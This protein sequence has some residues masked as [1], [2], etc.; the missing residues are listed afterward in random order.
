MAVSRTADPWSRGRAYR[1]VLSAGHQYSGPASGKRWSP[2]PGSHDDGELC[3]LFLGG[4]GTPAFARSLDG[5]F[6]RWHLQNGYHIHQAIEQAF[7]SVRWEALTDPSRNGYF[8]LNESAPTERSVFSL[9]PVTSELYRCRETPIEVMAEFYSP[10]LPQSCDAN[11]EIPTATLPVT[12]VTIAI[13]NTTEAPLHVDAACV[14]PNLLGWRAA[15][16]T[17]IDRS[18]R[19]WPAQT[20]AGNSA[21]AYR[22]SDHLA[23]VQTRHTTQTVYD[24]LMG[25]VAIL[26]PG[27]S[28]FGSIEACCKAEVN[29]IDRAPREQGHT[30]PWLEEHFRQYGTLP[31][32]GRVWTAQWDEALCSGLSQGDTLAAG[33]SIEFAF[34]LAFDMPIVRFGS[35]RR[36]YRKY[37]EAYGTRGRNALKI[38]MDASKA[39]RLWRDAIHNWQQNMLSHTAGAAM[40]NELYFVN[41]G[42][43]V[44]VSHWAADLDTELP[45]PRL[46]PGEHTAL[47]EGYDI[48]Y[49]YYNTSD[50]WP[51]A[52]Y[53]IWRW[54]PD[55]AQNVF[56]DLLQTVPLTMPEQRMI[57]RSET[58]EPVLIRS[59]IPHDVGSVMADPWHELNGYQ[60]RDDSNL[61]KDHNPAFI[62]SLFL[63]HYVSN[64][65]PSPGDW[66]HIRSAAL[67]AFHQTDT[68][69]SL[70]V[71]TTFGDSTW[72]NLGIRGYASY[73]A[74]FTL[75]SLAAVQRWS[76]LFDDPELYRECSHR[77][78]SAQT[79]MLKH[80]W[81]GEYFRV[82]TSGR[83]AD[84]IMG[85]GILGIFLA[86]LA[87]LSAL[88]PGISREYCTQHLHCYYEHC[89][90]QYHDGNVGPLLV[91]APGQTQFPSDGGD[92]LQVNEVL[93]GSA[94]LCAAMMAHYGL[95]QESSRIM[96]TLTDTVYGSKKSGPA[97]QF[98]T[99]AAFDA[100]GRFR[101]PMNM[102]PLSIWFLDAIQTAQS[103]QYNPVRSPI[104]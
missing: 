44:W 37:T 85:D 46:G 99:P 97:L 49:Y 59:K 55:F 13:R 72:D 47:L 102:R 86:D 65:N 89:F 32:S 67:F 60:M 57:Y 33:D 71:H 48:G 96:A 3:G 6:S 75:G 20:N 91:A 19:S 79:G 17:T 22:D 103:G 52:W 98:R 51:Y 54:W 2:K 21:R 29:P 41:G 43:T 77:L 35:G 90:L 16:C 8:R 10:L 12:F 38:A 24:E 5:Q 66:T 14:W 70:P 101:A 15:Q 39:M 62:L 58:M 93:P 92:E 30:L 87:G 53:A 4:I 84:C 95:D 78:A 94:W 73:S 74:G 83:Y 28:Q 25:E 45:P 82:C 18:L 27:S 68:N 104:P 80:L 56:S 61:W 11:R 76:E 69:A 40:A 23:V 64:T 31:D 9:F 26:S 100:E 36:W 63:F 88:L 1:D 50:L 42:G 81:N 34:V 7:F